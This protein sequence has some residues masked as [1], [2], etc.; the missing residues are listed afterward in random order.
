MLSAL[1]PLEEIYKGGAGRIKSCCSCCVTTQDRERLPAD[2]ELTEEPSELDD[3]LPPH[4]R[5]C[6][7][8]DEGVRMRVE[9]SRHISP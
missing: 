5:S 2:V 1:K 8:A 4:V 9:L 7:C 3:G 6:A